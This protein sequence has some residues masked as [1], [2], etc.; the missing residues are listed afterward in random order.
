[1]D[2]KEGVREINIDQSTISTDVWNLSIDDPMIP[3]IILVGRRNCP[4]IWQRQ[5]LNLHRAQLVSGGKDAGEDAIGTHPPT[6]SIFLQVALTLLSA[7]L[8]ENMAAFL[9]AQG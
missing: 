3:I 4:E 8:G 2:S 7:A 9:L 6:L 1:M 5:S